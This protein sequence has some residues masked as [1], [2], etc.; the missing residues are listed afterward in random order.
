M[1][2]KLPLICL[3]I[4]MLSSMESKS[5]KQLIVNIVVAILSAVITFLTSC[6]FK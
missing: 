6:T 2:L 5:I 3:N 4:Y 1:R